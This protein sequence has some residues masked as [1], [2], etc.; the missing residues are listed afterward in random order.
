MGGSSSTEVCM[1]EFSRFR[2]TE[3]YGW[4]ILERG[5]VMTT[6]VQVPVTNEA[7]KVTD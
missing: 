2:A 6:K 4:N 3:M 1:E 7:R 5:G